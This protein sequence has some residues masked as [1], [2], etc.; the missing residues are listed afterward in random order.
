MGLCVQ[1]KNNALFS[2]SLIYCYQTFIK[3]LQIHVGVNF[4]LRCSCSSFSDFMHIQKMHY[5][6][7]WQTQNKI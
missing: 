5:I 3:A 4:L 2:S 7:S 1:H 6:S